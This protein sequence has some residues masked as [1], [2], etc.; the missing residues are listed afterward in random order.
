MKDHFY[1]LML[2]TNKNDQALDKYLNFIAACIK[3]GVTSVQLREKNLSLDALLEFGRKLQSVLK[4][5]SIP[6]IV[7]DRVDIAYELDAD[8]VHLGQS[9]GCVLEARQKLGKDKIIGLTI[10]HKEQIEVSNKLPINYIGV[11]SIFPT[12][13]KEDIVTVW[14][15]KGLKQVAQI[16]KF[17]VVAI[18]GIDETNVSDVIKAGADGIA[19]I[20]AFHT[21]RD[22]SNVVQSLCKYIYGTCYDQANF[23]STSKAY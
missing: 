23:R 1:K 2:V 17:P 14:E 8:G 9:D 5:F 21:T 13:S 20:G 3:S 15:C 4:T 18:G 16:S 10:E 22:P 11:S 19:A 7:N 12:G 6:L